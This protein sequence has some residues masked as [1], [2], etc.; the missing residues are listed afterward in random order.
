ML[1]RQMKMP[2]EGNEWLRES[3]DD[4]R[5]A[6]KVAVEYSEARNVLNSAKEARTV[7]VFLRDTSATEEFSG[8]VADAC[9]QLAIDPSTENVSETDA[10][11]PLLV[12]TKGEHREAS[13]P[14]DE[15]EIH[16]Y[17]SNLLTA[18]GLPEERRRSVEDDI[19]KQG[20]IERVQHEF[21]RHL[22]PLQNLE[23]LRS[24]ATAYLY[25]TKYTCSCQL[26]GHETRIEND[27]LDVVIKAMQ[28][29]YCSEC[30]RREPR[31]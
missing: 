11:D 7:A 27:D 5:L 23:H 22:Q 17:A 29:V 13:W 10:N 31:A 20:Q 14:T 15:M 1:S 28:Q 24:P 9:R 3:M 30:D 2:K 8:L 16:E 19:R 12:A 6:T 18:T 26:L 25:T 4:F 21:C